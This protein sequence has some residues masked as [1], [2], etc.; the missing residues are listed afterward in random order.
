MP[1][2]LPEL[3]ALA[4][5]LGAVSLIAY[6]AMFELADLGIVLAWSAGAVAAFG[7]GRLLSTSVRAFTLAYVAGVT[8]IVMAVGEALTTIAPPS[9]LAV[10]PSVVSGVVPLV[11]ESSLGLAAIAL[12]L[13][14]GALLIPA[15]LRSAD[16][17][18]G[19]PSVWVVAAT[20]GGGRRRVSRLDRHR[21]CLR[22]FR[23]SREGDAAVE[24]ATQAQVALTIAWVVAGAVAFAA[25]IVANVAVPACSASAC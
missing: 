4:G 17:V 11:N 9:R 2:D 12:A 16:T 1:S 14:A 22:R 13:V 25:G 5:G 3:V 8:L 24:I 7:L 23:G 19:R 15:R 21:R 20:F 10:D 18:F 6:A